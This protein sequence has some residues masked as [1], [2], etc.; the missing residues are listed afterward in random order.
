MGE[1]RRRD[2]SSVARTALWPRQEP[3]PSRLPPGP[4]I[5]SLTEK[6]A[7][8]L[9]NLGVMWEREPEP[10]FMPPKSLREYLVRYPKG[11][12]EAVGEVAKELE[13]DLRN[14]YDLDDLAQDIVVMFLELLEEDL[15]DI[16]EMYPLQPP[17]RRGGCRS[18]HFHEYIR[19]RVRAAVL[20]EHELRLLDPEDFEEWFKS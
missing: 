10:D 15:E 13:A 8:W 14:F 20:S 11:I 9:L 1:A 17:M 16:V 2:V 19:L 6:D 3:P 18:A 7:R 12:R 5:P 4:L